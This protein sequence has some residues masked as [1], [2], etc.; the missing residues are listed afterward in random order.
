MLILRYAMLFSVFLKKGQRLW[1][2]EKTIK[3]EY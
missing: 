2:E 3:G 1:R